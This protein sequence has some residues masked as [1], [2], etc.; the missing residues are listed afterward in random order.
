MV[1]IRQAI[2]ALNSQ[3]PKK[4]QAIEYYPSTIPQVYTILVVGSTIVL[5]YWD[6]INE[7]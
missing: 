5:Y 7:D 6:I 1:D 4:Q 3:V 2:F